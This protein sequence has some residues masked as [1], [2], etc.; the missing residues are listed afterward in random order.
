MKYSILIVAYNAFDYL[1]KCLHSIRASA[2]EDFE[3]VVV[4]NSAD[5]LPP[6]L[7]DEVDTLIEGQGNIGFAAGC[8][9]AAQWAK[10]E[11][12][13]FLNPDTEVYGDWALRLA[14]PLYRVYISAGAEIKSG[15]P[16]DPFTSPVMQKVGAV[17]PVSDFVAGAQRMD[18]HFKPSATPAETA[19]WAAEHMDGQEEETKL[20]IGLCFAITREAWDEMGG[21][22]PVLFLGND[23]LDLSWRLREAGYRLIIAKDVFV[24]HAGHKSFETRPY[25]E[26][27]KLLEESEVALHGKLLD[28]YNGE[29]PSSTDLWGADF[30]YT[31]PQRRMTLSVVMIVRE[32]AE[33]LHAMVRQLGFA[34]QVVIVDTA[35]PGE[36]ALL[37]AGR[38]EIHQ[39]PWTEDF[40]AARNFS[41]SKA[42]GDWIMWLDADDRIPE[43]TGRLIRNGLDNPSRRMLQRRV[44]FDLKIVN[45][46]N[47]RPYGET[48]FQPRILPNLP[49]LQWENAIHESMVP[50]IMQLRKWRTLDRAPSADMVIHHTGYS[51][52]ELRRRKTER[53][54]RMLRAQVDTPQKYMD[55]GSAHAAIEQWTE[56][57][58]LWRWLLDRWSPHL[59]EPFR[60]HIRYQV[61][62]ALYRAKAYDEALEW[63]EENTKQDATYMVGD[64]L[65]KLGKDGRGYLQAYLDQAPDASAWG[66]HRYVMEDAA[67]RLLGSPLG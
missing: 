23:D 17:G 37:Q 55:M 46:E 15:E 66:S 32:E 33:N 42:T 6:D 60:D 4:N 59:E 56:A 25:G 38:A 29:P 43:E 13:I 21:M 57:G 5:P 58:A 20:I 63:F 18:R 48:F 16:G 41:K 26:V 31:G 52:P 11:T 36:E 8:N 7:A 51:T 45:V 40:A 1:E 14:K 9:L 30:F 19:A 44:F 65:L 35:L 62:V 39:F 3:V 27:A 47:G 49:D 24:H 28:Y 50:S 12:F 2:I 61:G 53:N 34:D 54:L 67:K 22:D 64:V 10:G